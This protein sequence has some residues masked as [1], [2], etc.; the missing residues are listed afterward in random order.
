MTEQRKPSMPTNLVESINHDQTAALHQ[1]IQRSF[2][3][4]PR[5]AEICVQIS[6]GQT[7]AAIGE[8]LGISKRTVD[9]HVERI[10]QKLQVPNRTAATYCFMQHMTGN[11]HK[12]DRTGE[13]TRRNAGDSERV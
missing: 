13:K 9:K 8:I 10:L 1:S 12:P 2:S 7:N 4:S 6:Q 3:L 5:Q 11:D